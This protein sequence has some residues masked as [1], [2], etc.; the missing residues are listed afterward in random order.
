MIT[1]LLYFYN[2]GIFLANEATEE[3]RKHK[4]KSGNK[5]MYGVDIST[6]LKLAR[7][8]FMRNETGSCIDIIKLMTRYVHAVKAEF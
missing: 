2:F 5:Y 8:Y 7:K 1:H 6:V 4:R 3:N